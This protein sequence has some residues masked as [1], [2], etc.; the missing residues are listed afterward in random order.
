MS[1]VDAATR[2]QQYLD[3]RR[4]D[5]FY[6]SPVIVH[7]WTGT[8]AVYLFADDLEAV[9]LERAASLAAISAVYRERAQF[10]A[11]LTRSY[12]S[13]WGYDADT[14]GWRVV[15]VQSPAG[16]L[17]WHI[18]PADWELFSHVPHDERHV[19]DGH[20]TSEKYERMRR[21]AAPDPD[22]TEIP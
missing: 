12:P 19:W 7:V 21:I 4:G 9:L 6:S 11:L 13:C 16:E 3:A 5:A 2:V 20:S 18:S 14:P 17:S 15:Y 8:H 1:L 22:V 10:I